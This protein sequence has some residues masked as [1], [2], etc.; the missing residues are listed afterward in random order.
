MKKILAIRTM[1][2]TI[3]T[4]VIKP[5]YLNMKRWRN[6][7]VIFVGLE[8]AGIDFAWV[9]LFFT[10]LL[11]LSMQLVLPLGGWNFNG[12][13]G[14]LVVC[15]IKGANKG[16]WGGKA[17]L[18]LRYELWE[19]LSVLELFVSI[20]IRWERSGL[21]VSGKKNIQ[22]QRA[23]GHNLLPLIMQHNVKWKQRNAGLSFSPTGNNNNNNIDVD[24]WEQRQKIT[25]LKFETY[26]ETICQRLLLFFFIN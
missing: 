9:L 19:T 18:S 5:K 12:K 2:R 25:S 21:L 14:V 1:R 15:T 20:I 11:F 6:D 22:S 7:F 13:S 26:C 3:N 23:R 4:K 10:L 24:T 8:I 16:H 17:S